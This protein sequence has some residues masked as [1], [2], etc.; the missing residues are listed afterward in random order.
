MF[1]RY[2]KL[3]TRMLKW[4]KYIM[5][6]ER[7]AAR[8]RR[9]LYLVLLRNPASTKWPMAK[10]SMPA[11]EFQGGG[12]STISYRDFSSALKVNVRNNTEILDKEPGRRNDMKVLNKGMRFVDLHKKYMDKGY[13]KEK[14]FDLANEEFVSQ[15]SEGSLDTRVLSDYARSG[16]ARNFSDYTKEVAVWLCS[17]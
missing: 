1:S 11:P 3:A 6:F 15:Q 5:S 13:D 14:A 17:L 9:L 4:D 10:T 7:G 8:H 2:S 16:G 12:S